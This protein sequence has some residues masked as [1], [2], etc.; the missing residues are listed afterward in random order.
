[1]NVIALDPGTQRTGYA[2]LAANGRSPKLLECDH[3]KLRGKTLPERL[4]HLHRELE[5]IF[6][7]RR[8]GQVAIERPFVGKSAR[9]AMTLAAGR[10]VCMLAAAGA[11]APVFEY[12]P[13]QV[14]KTV[15]GNGQASKAQVQRMVHLIFRLD[16]AP[17]HDAADALALAL[18]HVNRQ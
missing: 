2:V 16:E 9:A 1:M 3:I 15:T 4:L 6:R 14:K 10:A 18:C 13:A 5:K 7:R 8:P 11:K 12:A 17:Q